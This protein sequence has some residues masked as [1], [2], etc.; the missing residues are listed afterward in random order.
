MHTVLALKK[1][2][3]TYSISAPLGWKSDWKSVFFVFFVF[4]FGT[5]DMIKCG[6]C[7]VLNTHWKSINN[8]VVNAVKNKIFFGDYVGHFTFIATINQMALEWNWKVFHQQKYKPITNYKTLANCISL[9]PIFLCLT[10][11]NQFMYNS[12]QLVGWTKQLHTQQMIWLDKECQK[13]AELRNFFFFCFSGK[14][15][16]NYLFILVNL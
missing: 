2:L 7:I 4:S 9:R 8:S 6:Y 15:W 16:C 10:N 13:W 5:F 3:N 14:I 12:A 1:S 11:L